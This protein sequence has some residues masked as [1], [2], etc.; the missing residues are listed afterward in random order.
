MSDSKNYYAV[1]GVKPGDSHDVIKKKYR[2][3]AF[4]T[5]PDKDP[6][7]TAKFQEI[8]EAY[9]V[10]GNAEKRRQY[11]S[12]GKQ[13]NQEDI[14]INPEDIFEF[15]RKMPFGGQSHF[16]HMDNTF[17]TPFNPVLQKPTPIIKTIKISL[18]QAY[19]GCKLPIEI[20][21][22]ICDGALK[23]QEKETVY[24]T[25]PE[26]IDD[27]EIIILKEKGNVLNETNKGDVKIFVKVN[28]NTELTRSGL[29]L[30]FN[31]VIT[32]KESLCGFTFD[33]EYLDERIFKID[34]HN[35]NVI[36]P[37][38]KKLIPGLGMKRDGHKGNLIIEFTV[39][40]PDKLTEEQ[41]NN[42]KDHL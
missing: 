10:L 26:G 5:H 19:T 24:L 15:I 12:T 27:N 9:D 7:G 13:L 36:S 32:L 2:K 40:F 17:N 30:V 34:N 21:R 8:N 35:G 6:N 11:D 41:I 29:E 4:I 38:Y 14:P 28:N 16:F 42:I 25:V 3:L 20:E 31:K 1:L 39:T 33:M 18:A 22:W 37:G 23:Q